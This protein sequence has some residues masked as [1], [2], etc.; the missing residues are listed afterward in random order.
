MESLASSLRDLK[1][2]PNDELES[3]NEHEFM[4]FRF[5]D[6]PAE[7]R[8]KILDYKYHLG[9]T[10][11]IDLRVVKLLSTFFVSKQYYSEAAQSFYSSNTFRLLPTHGAAGHP[12]KNIQPL[13]KWFS[14]ASRALITSLEV[15]LGPFW[16]K[17]PR[18]WVI[19]DALGLED[20]VSV[21]VL[22]V[23]IEVDPAHAI[24]GGFRSVKLSYTAFCCGLL[25][26][27]ISRLPSI[28]EVEFDGYEHVWL[29]LPLMPSLIQVARDGGM[30][31]SFGPGRPDDRLITQHQLFQCGTDT[32][33]GISSNGSRRGSMDDDHGMVQF[34]SSS[35]LYRNMTSNDVFA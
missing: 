16:T 13:I 4:P 3:E 6:L 8:R 34:Y 35:P 10:L 32:R 11:D 2:E 23:F 28:R 25:R 14:T 24:F 12:K 30:R 15:R 19:D 20:A 33:S 7:L 29:G 5:F 26:D 31:V 22:K 1:V 17:P 27:I 18:C 9:K 21:R